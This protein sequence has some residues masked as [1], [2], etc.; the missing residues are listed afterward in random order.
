MKRRPLGASGLQVA[1]IGLGCMGMSAVYE[2]G[3]KNDDDSMGVIRRAI[4]LGVTLFDTSDVYGPY[5]NE[6]LLGRAIAGRR[7]EVVVATKAGCVFRPNTYVPTT[8]C[9]P[10]RLKKCCDESLD[11]L[12]VEVI[13][14]WQL[15]R[16][17][18]S[19]PIEESVGAMGEMVEAGKVRAIGVSEVSIAQL[20]A[21]HRSHPLAAV[22]Y[23]LSLWSRAALDDV[24]PWCE[25]HDVALVPYSPLGRGFLTGGIGPDRTFAPD[26]ARAVHPRFTP[27]ALHAN[28]AIVGGVRAVAD[29]LGASVAQVALAWVL[30]QGDSVIPIPGPDR[31]DQLEEDLGAAAVVLDAEASAALAVLPAPVS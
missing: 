9:R 17:D 1:E 31:I 14:L 16:P 26:D 3:T 13:D 23:E 21:A 30:A 4:D 19:V 18:P 12:G 20:E 8:D 27:E 24:L 15:H 10:E 5:T 29:R 7:E 11:R 22:Q 28:Q 25:A 6:K 2:P